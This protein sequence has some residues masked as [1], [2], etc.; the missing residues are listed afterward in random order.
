MI[1]RKK[2]NEN[3]FLV[4]GLGNPGRK[5]QYTRHNVGFLALDHIAEKAGVRVSRSRFSSLVGE[6]RIGNASATLMKPMTYMNLSGQ[7]VAAAARYYGTEPDHIVV[8]CDDAALDPGV[9]RIRDHGSSG[10]QKG[11]LSIEDMLQSSSYIR[12]R[13]GIGHC[14]SQELADYVLSMPSSADRELISRRFPD[15]AEA[16]E[17]IVKGDLS[18]AQS[19]FNGERTK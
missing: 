15:I 12:I 2:Q 5:Y 14:D 13:V 10:G 16:L 9:I 11:L 8:I 7:A 19:R 3:R 4:A 6:G 18:G 1:F 17:M